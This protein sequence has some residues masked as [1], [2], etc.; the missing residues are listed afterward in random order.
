LN[1]NSVEYV[2]KFKGNIE[3]IKTSV[4]NLLST[5]DKTN[6]Y[7]VGASI[8]TTHICNQFKISQKIEY[9][10]DDDI[11]KIGKHAPGSGIEVKSLSELPNY[12][13]SF[14]ILLA[15]QHTN[16]II[17]RLKEVK[18]RGKVLIP[19]PNPTIISVF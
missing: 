10:F 13:D 2:L 18:F 17:N 3:N 12:S 9:I 11:N 4:N 6:I 7:G 19:L 1:C 5:I 15:W 16:R 8:S 14:L